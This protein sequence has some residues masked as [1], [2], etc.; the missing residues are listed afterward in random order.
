MLD[1]VTLAV[2]QAR[3]TAIVEEMG[4]ALLRTAYSQIL[5]ASRDF[6]IALFDAQARLVAQAD[7]IPIHVGALPDAI[8]AVQHS[9]GQ[10]IHEG[11]IFLLN[12]PWNGGSHLPDLTYI[13][14]V[15]DTTGL[16][17][18][19]SIVRAHQSDIGGATYGGYNAAATD[20]WQ[21]GIRIPPIRLGEGGQV[22]DDLLTMLAANTRGPRDF[23]GDALA[24]L[25]ATRLGEKR[26]HEAFARFGADKVSAAATQILDLSEQQVRAIVETWKDGTWSAEAQLDDDGR[27]NTGITVRAT[28]TKR[29]ASITV[30]LSDSDPQVDSFINS[31]PANTRSAVFIAFAF[32]LNPDVP[33]NDGVLRLLDVKMREGTIACAREGA[34]VNLCTNHCGQ[35]I[36]EAVVKALANACPD[37]AMAAW[38][39]RFRIAISGTDPR[40]H[41]PFVWHL[42]HARPGS[43]ASS[44]GDGWNC[45]GEWQAAGG[46][47]FGSVEMAEVRFPLFFERHELRPD[48]GGDGQHR[49]GVGGHAVIR[50]ET[51]GT[52]MGNTAGEGAING[53]AGLLGGHDGKPHHYVLRRP[54]GTERV[55]KSKEVGI[56]I[57]PN[58]VLDVQAGGGGGWGPPQARDPQARLHDRNEGVCS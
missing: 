36:L 39:K 5:N 27:G 49:G 18:F 40:T 57:K 16:H 55:L 58:D 26:L 37:R 3:F 17:R 13:M 1:P 56:V 51:A 24:A 33:K 14:P 31:S 2:L 21:E 42:F 47:K 52:A 45:G 4:E 50:V 10:D 22:R 6:S 23:R 35:E 43:G 12:D 30:D 19:W 46:L 34:A 20:I 48:S 25:G 11:D 44:A 38:G 9:F 28:V 29:G 7:H 32:L 8:K 54:D 41:K 15:F 53:S